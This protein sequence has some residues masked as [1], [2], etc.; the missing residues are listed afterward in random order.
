MTSKTKRW[1]QLDA[2]HHLHP[3]SDLKTMRESVKTRVIDRAEGVY[4]YDSDGEGMLDAMS[5]LWCMNMGYGRQELIDA[6]QEQFG[7]LPYYN[8]FFNTTHAPV[9]ELSDTL[10]EKQSNRH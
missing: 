9:A 10:P 8:S 1:Q 3:F 2:K 4:I 5:G 6:A 7:K